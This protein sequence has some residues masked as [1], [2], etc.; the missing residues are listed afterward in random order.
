M[1]ELNNPE[2]HLARFTADLVEIQT[3]NLLY[4]HNDKTLSIVKAN[5]DLHFVRPDYLALLK[6]HGETKYSTTSNCPKVL[7][8]P[9]PSILLKT[10]SSTS[11]SI[12]VFATW[13]A[14]GGVFIPF[15]YIQTSRPL[16]REP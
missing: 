9:S 6:D 5:D 3:T 7:T 12:P 16:S 4:L 10:T 11:S 8:C 14:P 1:E 15:T 13:L 2:T